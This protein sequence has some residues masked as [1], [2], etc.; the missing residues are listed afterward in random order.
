[1]NPVERIFQS[2]VFLRSLKKLPPEL[3][4]EVKTKEAIF[5]K[6]RFHPHLKTHKLKGKYRDVWSFSITR[7]H[8]IVFKFI[9]KNTVLFVD[10][11]DH[12]IYQ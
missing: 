3:R 7:K 6:D 8:R 12:S 5:R 9:D 10:V 11:G 4:E 1:M 2:S